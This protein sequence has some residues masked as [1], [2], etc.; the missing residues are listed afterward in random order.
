[1]FLDVDLL[2]IIENIVDRLKTVESF[3]VM[4]SISSAKLRNLYVYEDLI[5]GKSAS[6]SFPDV[7]ENLPAVMCYTTGTTGKPKGLCIL[8]EAYFYVAWLHV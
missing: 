6:F 7:N 3:V 2:P 5:N 1:M 4:D 8:I